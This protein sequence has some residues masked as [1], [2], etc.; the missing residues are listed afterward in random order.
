[1]GPSGKRLD[2]V[3]DEGADQLEARYLFLGR[4]PELPNL[5]HHWLCDRHLFFG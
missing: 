1:V 4:G 5:L 2:Q 3:L